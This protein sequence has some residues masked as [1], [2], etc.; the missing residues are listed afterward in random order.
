MYPYLGHFSLS[1]FCSFSPSPPHLS[2]T[3]LCPHHTTT[4]LFA[5]FLSLPGDPTPRIILSKIKPFKNPSAV[6]PCNQDQPF[7][8]RPAKPHLLRC[9][10]RRR[11]FPGTRQALSHH[12]AFARAVPANL[13]ILLAFLL[14]LF[15]LIQVSAR[16]N[17]G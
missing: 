16:R 5:L 1:Y 4:D 17:P 9:S 15:P 8:P 2:L 12:R 6:C 13:E 7:L 3:G 11:P 10:S 14:G